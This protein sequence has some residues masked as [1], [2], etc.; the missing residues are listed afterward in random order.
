MFLQEHDIGSHIQFTDKIQYVKES[1][2]SNFL[3]V[4]MMSLYRACS[5]CWPFALA[6]CAH[7]DVIIKAA[8]ECIAQVFSCRV[9]FLNAHIFML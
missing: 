1:N 3:L 8:S 5:A 2:N 9:D 4:Q 6:G 7:Y